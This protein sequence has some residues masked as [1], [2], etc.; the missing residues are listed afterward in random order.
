MPSMYSEPC[1]KLT[2]RVTPKMSDSP[3]ATRKSVEAL[4]RPF[5]NCATKL[6]MAPRRA[7][8]LFRRPQ[9]P[10]LGVGRLDLRTVHVAERGHDAPAVLQRQAADESA[11]GRLVIERAVGDAAERRVDGEALHRRDQLLGVGAARLGDGG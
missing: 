10:H 6:D 11:H 1:A 9:L 4:A 3:D 2:T 8:R 7:R 5:R